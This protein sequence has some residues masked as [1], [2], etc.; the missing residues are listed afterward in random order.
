MSRF[1]Q[2]ERSSSNAE[3]QIASR[4]RRH[5]NLVAADFTRERGQILGSGDDLELRLRGLREGETDESDSKNSQ[6][7]LH[8]NL[9]TSEPRNP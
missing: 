4:E 5:G 6:C 9:G 8:M 3:V 7:C 1:G 2:V